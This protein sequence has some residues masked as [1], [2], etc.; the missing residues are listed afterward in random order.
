MA[1]YAAAAIGYYEGDDRM[2]CKQCGKE[3]PDQAKFCNF[4][5]T[6]VEVAAPQPAPAAQVNAAPAERQVQPKNKKGKAGIIILIVIIVLA[7]IGRYAER[8]FQGQGYGS[9]DSAGYLLNSSGDNGGEESGLGE[10]DLMASCMNGA[11]YKDG[12]LTYGL[13][14]IQIPGYS[15]LEN[16]GSTVDYLV[17]SDR[18]TMVGVNQRIETINASFDATQGEDI[19]YTYT[20]DS[21]YTNVSM[22]DFKKY[23]VNGYPVISYVAAITYDGLD[24]YIGELIIFPGKNPGKTMRITME[25]LASNGYGG[26]TQA[27]DTLAISADYEVKSGDT[28]YTGITRITV[29]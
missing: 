27:F 8:Y 18:T 19:L 4:C 2:Y 3:I 11:L 29:K 7:G 14:R 5:G 16:T 12:Y 1:V 23:E 24:E 28:D 9:G 13:A 22:Y 25:T 20:S 15:L 6:K 21:H 26:I 17:S 10:H